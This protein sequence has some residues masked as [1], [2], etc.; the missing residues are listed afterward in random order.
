MAHSFGRIGLAL[1][2]TGF[3]GFARAE[4]PWYVSGSL[5][6]YFREDNEASGHFV[7]TVTV[8]EPRIASPPA[9]VA[10][11]PSAPP[12][13]IVVTGTRPPPSLV[14]VSVVLHAVGVEKVAHQ[15]GESLNLALGY[16]VNARFRVEVEAGYTQYASGSLRPFTSNPNFP[17]LDGRA[18]RQN[19]GGDYS[20]ETATLNSF[21][22]L[23]PAGARWAPYLGLGV[24][25]AATRRTTGYFTSADGHNFRSDGGSGVSGLALAEAGLN[26]RLAPNLTLA[27]AYRYVRYFNANADIAH[28]IRASL[29]YAF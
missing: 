24:G 20:R 6:G 14:P 26:I 29:R 10:P 21:Y 5:G 9:T 11:P 12:G 16:R 22:D 19:T 25:A 18:F 3:A 28:V 27:P 15:P 8:L 7:K 1:A 2:A 13:T 23:R 17:A 4:T